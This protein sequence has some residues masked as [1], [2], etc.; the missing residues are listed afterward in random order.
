MNSPL[1]DRLRHHYADRTTRE[2]LPGPDVDEA[3]AETLRRAERRA[4]RTNGWFGHRRSTLWLAT[5]AALAT[6]LGVAAVLVVGDDEPSRLSTD[7]GTSTSTTTTRPT[8]T[9]TST[10]TPSTTAATTTTT[11]GGP[12]PGTNL[13]IVAGVDGVL[14]WWDGSAWVDAEPGDPL[15]GG[16][17]EEFQIV[18]LDEPIT[19]G[20]G[21][22]ISGGCDPSGSVETLSVGI[23]DDGEALNPEPIAVTGVADPRPRSVRQIDPNQPELTAAASQALSQVGVNAPNPTVV[24]AVQADLDGDG[25]DEIV[26]VT[27]RLA[28]GEQL[29]AADGDY[30]VMFVGRLVDGPE[31]QVR[32]VAQSVFVDAPN[33]TP[34]IDAWRVAALADLNGDGRMEIVADSRYYE[35]RSMH[36]FELGSDLATTEVLTSG[37]GA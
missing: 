12:P 15:P 34:A 21:Q 9:S 3:L 16:D 24:Q 4:A 5:A 7:E 11:T 23:V 14:G 20:V 33:A 10:S 32:V 37:C 29:L 28:N 1:E 25:S 26:A 27:E 19:T 2:P 36:A 31:E 35:G 13:S 22:T 6:A 30:S 17:G 8:S 18:R